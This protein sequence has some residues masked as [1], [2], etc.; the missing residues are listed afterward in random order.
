MVRD[1]HEM[2]IE[3][4]EMTTFNFNSKEYQEIKQDFIECKE[5]VS[6]FDWFVKNFTSKFKK[7]E[8]A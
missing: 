4:S 6:G 7:A 8:I 1:E 3:Y 2:L 5:V